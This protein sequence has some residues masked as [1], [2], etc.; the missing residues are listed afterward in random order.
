MNF[1]ELTA[2]NIFVTNFVTSSEIGVK[3]LLRTLVGKRRGQR[4]EAVVA[5]GLSLPYV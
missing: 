3:E 5:H 1:S 4:P 2:Q